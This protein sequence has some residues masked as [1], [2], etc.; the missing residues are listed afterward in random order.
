MATGIIIISLVII[1]ITVLTILQHIIGG[2]I[3]M[4]HYKQF[5]RNVYE[6]AE[7]VL[8]STFLGLCTLAQ[9]AMFACTWAM[10][11][12]SRGTATYTTD[13]QLGKRKVTITVT[14]EE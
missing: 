11:K 9:F 1:S 7:I 3:K 4:R 12:M 8:F 10:D 6:S 5:L 13:I 14:T 2:I